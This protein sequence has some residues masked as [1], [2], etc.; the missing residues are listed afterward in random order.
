MSQLKTHGRNYWSVW[1]AVV[2]LGWLAEPV[3][4][5]QAADLQA[6]YREGQTFLTWQEDGTVSGEWYCV[7]VSAQPITAQNLDQARRVAKIPE[8]S[9][10]FQFLRNVNVQAQ[11]FWTNLVQEPWYEAIQ[12]EDDE[13]GAKRLAAGTGLFVRTIHAPAT[14]YYAVTVESGGVED[15]TAPAALAA[16]VVEAVGTPGAVLQLKLDDRYYLYAFFCDYEVWNPDGIEDNWEGYVHVFH[17]RAPA[18]GAKDTQEP[19]PSM[20][21]L[22]A[23]AAWDDW[24][25]PYCTPDTHVSVKQLDYHLTW[26][27]GYSDNLPGTAPGTVVNFTERRVLQVARWLASGPTNFPFAVDPGRISVYGGSMGGTGTHTIGARNGDVFA[28]AFADEGIQNWALDARWNRWA[29]NVIDKWGTR[30]SPFPPWD[31][32]PVY[33]SLNQTKQAAEHPER[34]TPFLDIGQGIIDYVIPFHDVNK[35][36][37]ALETG[38]HPYAAT[39]GLFDHVPWAGPASVMDYQQIRSDELVPAFANASCNTRLDSTFRNLADSS[40]MT[41][42]TLS[43][44]SGALRADLNRVGQNDDDGS[45]NFTNLVGK[46]LV[47]GPA[48]LV[49]TTYF[50]IASNTATTLTIESGDLVA[51]KPALTSSQLSTLTTQLGR[52][53]TTEEIDARVEVLK[54]RFLICDGEPIG[55]WNAHFQWSTR[56]QN[57]DTNSAAD[58]LVDATTNLAICLRVTTH[59]RSAWNETSATADVTPR[60]CRNFRSVPGEPVH[61]QNWDMSVP[62]SPVLR[63]QGQVVA[64]AHG[65]VTVPGFVIGRSGWGS[66]LT[67][68]RSGTYT[69]PVVTLAATSPT[70]T[71]VGPTVGQFTVSRGTRTDGDQVVAF[72]LGGTATPGASTGDYTLGFSSTGTVDYAAKTGSVTLAAGASEATI[73]VTPVDDVVVE[74]PETVL[75]A[76]AGGSYFYTVGAPSNA[77]GV[78]VRDAAGNITPL[79]EAG[80]DQSLTVN[81]LPTGTVS[82]DG[83]LLYDDG[84]PG[85]P[86]YAWSQESGPGTVTFGDA[87]QLVTTATFSQAGIHVLRLTAD[88]GALQG[89]DTVTVTVHQN[90]APVVDAG[91]DRSVTLAAGAVNLDGTLTTDDGLPATPA[92]VYAWTKAS[93]PGTVTFGNA[94]LIDTT[95]AFSQGGVYG[96]RLT[97]TDGLGLSG[98]DTVTF[99]VLAPVS[100]TAQASGRFNAESTWTPA[101]G[102]PRSG[103]TATIGGGFTVNTLSDNEVASGVT[104][105]LQNTGKLQLAGVVTNAISP[106]QTGATVNVASG[107]TLEIQSTNNVVGTINLNGGTIDHVGSSGNIAVGAVLNINSNSFLGPISAALTKIACPVHGTGKLTLTADANANSAGIQFAA[108]STWSGGWDF[109]GSMRFTPSPFQQRWIPGDVRVAA[110]KMVRCDVPF[111]T[112]KG[113]RSGKGLDRFT[114]ANSTNAIGD[115]TGNGVLSPGDGAGGVGGVTFQG[116]VSSN[117]SHTLKFSAG[118]TYVVDVNGTTTNAYD[119]VNVVGTGTGTG[120]VQVIPGAK[121]TLNLWTPATNTV[122]DATVIDGTGTKLDAGDFSG[123]VTW[124]NTSGWSGLATAWVGADLHVTGT[125]TAGG[126]GDSNSNDVPDVW[127]LQYFGNLTNRV[128]DDADG[129]GLSNYGE[130]LAG[131]HPTNKQSVLA[132]TNML[133]NAGGSTV[134]RWASESNRYYTLRLST[135][136]VLDPFSTALTNRASATPPMNVHTDSVTRPRGAYYK[137]EVGL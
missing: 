32:V 49:N 106:I 13:N 27:Y 80:A 61:W 50:R 10:H 16:P 135:N 100:Y 14:N 91:V 133:Q 119:I 12:I 84:V 97:A 34:E 2:A 117:A 48:A 137:I 18:A 63:A 4:A 52:D 131:T 26:W 94:A 116:Y 8:G 41:A 73:T 75:L 128:L 72:T 83:S 65:L 9:R 28:S 60:R 11:E 124:N 67:M 76:L 71:E 92:I 85:A 33:D 111:R 51:Y 38:K 45:G 1:L 114:A 127:E 103:D 62:A 37:Q 5:G 120:N 90:A 98:T 125:Y 53:P 112:I 109:Q 56:R 69:L 130:W 122:L 89:S 29:P 58:E 105:N 7:Y 110:G 123:N 118:S 79:V 68:S 87:T 20:F 21:R 82:L 70:A 46:T 101:G 107:A 59:P 31:G 136:L 93:G 96:L 129:D 113:T 15:R 66:K 102:P 104:V 17:I 44:A 42:T 55:V 86:T 30:S 36:W 121:L 35:H 22:H 81:T 6:L 24:Q 115:G 54:K 43:I 25:I 23:Y 40:G 126:G 134:V 99:T 108:T 64:D 77:T 132:F 57:F 95:A 19:Y 74:P 47:L 88:D 3:R 39:W 78:I